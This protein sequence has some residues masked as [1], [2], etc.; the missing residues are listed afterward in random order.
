MKRV[1]V[2]ILVLLFGSMIG[3]AQKAPYNVVFDLTSRDS[4]DQKAAIRWVTEVLKGDPNAKIEVV[5]YGKGFEL[6]MPEKSQFVDQVKEASK[7]P[8]V[9]FKVCEVALRNNKVERS[10]I[11]KEVQTVPDGIYEIISKQ[12]EGWGYIKVVH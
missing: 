6:V 5:M 10:Q 11:L 2:T 4:L 8:N 9:S 12:H 3:Y 1:H 7:S